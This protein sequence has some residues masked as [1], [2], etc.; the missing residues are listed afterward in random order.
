MQLDSTNA[1]AFNNS[2]KKAVQA[3]TG[4]DVNVRIINSY[5]FPR[6]WAE[7]SVK[8]YK[9]QSFTNEF[10]LKVFDAFGFD[11][12][13][14]LHA[15]NV[16]YGNVRPNMISGIVPQWEKLFNSTVDEKL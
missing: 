12:K 2:L 10:R 8:D 13:N 6:C 14:L 4:Q 1:R 5:K 9:T 7:I 16:C 11:R 3:M 15:D